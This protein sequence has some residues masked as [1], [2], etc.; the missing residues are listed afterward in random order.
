M[1][2]GKKAKREIYNFDIEK[3]GK[4]E[5]EEKCLRIQDRY[6]GEARTPLFY[7]LNTKGQQ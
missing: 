3:K 7:M 4:P 1:M 6:H 2:E 5:A